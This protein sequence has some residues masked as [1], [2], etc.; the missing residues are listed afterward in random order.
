M[1]S[2]VLSRLASYGQDTQHTSL[3]TIF[4]YFSLGS[5]SL[6]RRTTLKRLMA[7]FLAFAV[8]WTER[9][10]DFGITVYL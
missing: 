5:H 8:F 3:R 9:R 4:L 7:P 6:G 2:V 10:A 1:Y